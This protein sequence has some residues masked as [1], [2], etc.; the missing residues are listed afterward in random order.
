MASDLL[1]PVASSW[2]SACNASRSS[3]TLIAEDTSKAYHV[4]SYTRGRVR[5]LRLRRA[6]ASRVDTEA[7]T[8]KPDRMHGTV[9]GWTAHE[10]I[11]YGEVKAENPEG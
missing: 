10:P 6:W 3:R 4:L 11:G 9:I 8:P 5:G 1:R 7:G 2:A